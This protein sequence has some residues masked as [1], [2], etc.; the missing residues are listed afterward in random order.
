[1]VFFIPKQFHIASVGNDVIH[2]GSKVPEWGML[3]V[4]VSTPWMPVQEGLG[5]Q[6]PLLGVAQ[7]SG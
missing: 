6:F 7:S 4:G 2:M 5:I 3:L 1:M